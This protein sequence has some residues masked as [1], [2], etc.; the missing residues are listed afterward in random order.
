M[1]KFYLLKYS[2]NWA[3]EMDI[4]GHAVLTSEEYNEFNSKVD[5]LE[6][7]WFSVGTNEDIEYE[8]NES[9]KRAYSVSAIL[10]DDVDV[11]D[12]LGIMFRGYADSFVE[13]VLNAGEDE[14]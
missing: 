6:Y 10:E 13:A 7:L 4:D 8:S 5:E 9:I 3:D 11:L 1:S 2:D 14:W 12:R